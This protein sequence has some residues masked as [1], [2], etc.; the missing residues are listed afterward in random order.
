VQADSAEIKASWV[1]AISIAAGVSP[2]T[3]KFPD[4]FK[5]WLWKKAAKG[6]AFQRHLFVLVEEHVKEKRFSI[7]NFNEVLSLDSTLPLCS[8][9]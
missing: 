9:A 8:C 4:S 1:E 3:A 6:A 5:G 7:A 2:E